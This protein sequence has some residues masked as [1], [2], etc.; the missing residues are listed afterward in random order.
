MARP[1]T[2]TNILEMKGAFTKNPQRARKSEPKG[3]GTFRKTAPPHL[4]EEQKAVWRE[5]VRLVPAGVLTGSDQVVV[6]I[7][8]VLLEEFRRAGEDMHAARLTR[9]CA[10][11][12]RL[13]LDPSGRASLA[14]EKPREDPFEGL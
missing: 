6:E 8:A 13:G 7:A 10:L 2:A 9:L 11:L 1:R 14:I 3:K 4:N 5:V 12:G